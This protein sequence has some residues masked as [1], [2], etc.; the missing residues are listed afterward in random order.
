MKSQE[1]TL[2]RQDKAGT[3]S[4]YKLVGN[5]RTKVTLIPKP[6]PND[7]CASCRLDEV[8]RVIGSQNV[9]A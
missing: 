6:Q 4:H 1:R 3:V 2:V 9:G 5:K 8:I 7:N